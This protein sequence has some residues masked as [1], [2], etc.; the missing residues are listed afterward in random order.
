MKET[1]KWSSEVEGEI[2]SLIKD[3][4]KSQ[5]RTQ[6]ELSTCLQ[7]ETTRMQSVLQIL[8]RKYSLGGFPKVAACLCTIEEQWSKTTPYSA[9]ENNAPQKAEVDPFG[10]LDLILDDIRESYQE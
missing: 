8:K 3:W 5:S 10:Q 4:L 9:E 2:T 6:S 1:S 7:A